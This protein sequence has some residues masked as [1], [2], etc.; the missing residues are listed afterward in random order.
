MI[1]KYKEAFPDIHSS[2]FIAENATIIGKA[3]IQEGSSVWYNSV[4]R[5]DSDEIFI[6]KNS[7]IQDNCTLHT[8]LNHKLYIGNH[9]TI[10]HQAILHGAYVEDEVLIGMGAIILNGAHIGKHSIIAAGALVP[11]N[12][13]IPENSVVMGCPAKIK[14]EITQEQIDS[15]LHNAEHYKELGQEYTE[16]EESAC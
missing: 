15:I 13:I 9:V 10:G 6:G 3:I 5:A 1:K 8:D 14:K 4:V 2:C 12:M 7:N 16:M 11:E